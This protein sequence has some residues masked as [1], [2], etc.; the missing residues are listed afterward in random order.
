MMEILIFQRLILSDKP[1][2]VF[3]LISLKFCE[4]MQIVFYEKY[5]KKIYSGGF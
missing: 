5:I 4:K 1:R 3:R 2:T